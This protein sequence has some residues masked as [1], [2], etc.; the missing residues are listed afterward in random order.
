MLSVSNSALYLLAPCQAVYIKTVLRSRK[1][2]REQTFFLHKSPDMSQE[3]PKATKHSTDCLFIAY[4]TQPL[5]N[6]NT[7]QDHFQMSSY[8]KKTK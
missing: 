7:D 6:N 2:V 1:Y 4:L 5:K 8:L 3:L